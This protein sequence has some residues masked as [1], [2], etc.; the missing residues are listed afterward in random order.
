MDT[1]AAAA[2]II[3]EQVVIIMINCCCVPS[4]FRQL[5]YFS[6]HL[7]WGLPWAFNVSL[8]ALRDFAGCKLSLGTGLYY[9]HID[10]K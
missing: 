5:L 2:E 4:N 1:S 9:L 7:Y 8:S 3:A 6:T 10:A